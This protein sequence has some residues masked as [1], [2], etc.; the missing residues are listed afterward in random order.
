MKAIPLLTIGLGA[1]ALSRLDIAA[2][3]LGIGLLRL[4]AVAAIQKAQ[5]VSSARQVSP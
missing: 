5:L 4:V 1:L 2:L 3:A